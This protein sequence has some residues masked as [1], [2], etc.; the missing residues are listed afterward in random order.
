MKVGGE[1]GLAGMS[2]DGICISTTSVSG[3]GAE[4]VPSSTSA[5]G[6]LLQAMLPGGQARNRCPCIEGDFDKDGPTEDEE[7]DMDEM[8]V[9]KMTRGQLAFAARQIVALMNK[10]A[11]KFTLLYRP[12]HPMYEFAKLIQL[13]WTSSPN[14]AVSPSEF[15]TQIQRYVPRFVGYNQQDAQEFLRFLLDGLHSEV[16]RVLVRPRSNLDNLDH[17]P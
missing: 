4:L 2:I 12:L 13:L 14:E 1:D 16:N 9:L 6:Q 8:T 17:L 15:K 11:V 10:E 5:S 3:S 7:E